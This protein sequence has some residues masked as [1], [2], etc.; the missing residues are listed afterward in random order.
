MNIESQLK[1]YV[2]QRW[3]DSITRNQAL[4][5]RLMNEDCIL[6]ILRFLSIRDLLAFEQVE[7]GTSGSMTSRRWEEICEHKRFNFDWFEL[8][9]YPPCLEDKQHYLVGQASFTVFKTYLQ[10]RLFLFKKWA[11]SP[12]EQQYQ[13]V[14]E[15]LK[16][17]NRF[18]SLK[19]YM[20]RD[21]AE[22][23]H[24][25]VENSFSCPN[26]QNLKAGDWL[27]AGLDHLTNY[28]AFLI[29]E[30]VGKRSHKPSLENAKTCLTRAIQKGATGASLLAVC[31][32]E[33]FF[34]SFIRDSDLDQFLFE[35]AQL[36]ITENDAKDYSGL[37]EYLKNRWWLANTK[38]ITYAEFEESYLRK[39]GN[40]PPI[41]EY[42]AIHSYDQPRYVDLLEWEQ[43]EHLFK[44]AVQS[45][46]E[47]IPPQTW[48]NLSYFK[49]SWADFMRREWG[50]IETYGRYKQEEM[51][52]KR[53]AIVAWEDD[54]EAIRSFLRERLVNLS[55]SLKELDESKQELYAYYG[56]KQ[57][58][59]KKEID[60]SYRKRKVKHEWGLL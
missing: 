4:T 38:K 34:K 25:S 36:S 49:R 11:V 28:I 57:E 45:Y 31:L 18:C 22:N 32:S 37:H 39:G 10:T 2:G 59:Y 1:P 41:L 13:I 51:L 24:L 29:N 56:N 42:T 52:Y 5:F 15:Y 16:P 21:I 46:G 40:S 58:Q 17:F 9:K 54:E 55:F 14:Q 8:D 47:K 35:M 53:L 23:A 20:T 33:E 50:E 19:S 30:E 48:E 3:E 7:K 26:E 43:A 6:N 60:E 27:L 12:K 44:K